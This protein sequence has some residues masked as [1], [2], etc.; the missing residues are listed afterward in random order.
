MFPNISKGFNMND[1]SSLQHLTSPKSKYF[2][3]YRCFNNLLLVFS[4]IDMERVAIRGWSYGKNNRT[5]VL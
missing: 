2:D 5:I 4:F 3:V 1:A